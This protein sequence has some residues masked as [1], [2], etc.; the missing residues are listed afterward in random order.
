MKRAGEQRRY[1]TPQRTTLTEAD[2]QTFATANDDRKSG[3]DRESRHRQRKE[4]MT[5]QRAASSR[6]TQ[7][8][9]IFNLSRTL[10]VGSN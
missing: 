1:Q 4:N 9:A 6:C 7:R 3:K 10:V 2:F 5:H 8:A